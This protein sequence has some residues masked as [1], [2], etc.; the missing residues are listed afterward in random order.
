M[1]T[2]VSKRCGTAKWVGGDRVTYGRRQ[3]TSGTRGPVGTFCPSGLR[4]PGSSFEPS[5]G[6]P[7]TR[8]C[9]RFLVDVKKKS[10]FFG[11]EQLRDGFHSAFRHFFHSLICR[12]GVRSCGILRKQRG[13]NRIPRMAVGFAGAVGDG[14]GR[15]SYATALGGHWGRRGGWRPML[16]RGGG[17]IVSGSGE[18]CNNWGHILMR[19]TKPPKKAAAPEHRLR[20]A[21]KRGGKIFTQVLCIFTSR[22]PDRWR[23]FVDSKQPLRRIGEKS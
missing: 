17:C 23:I 8:N 14:R 3:R 6:G 1:C 11:G 2:F 10:C 20:W 7:Q 13:L 9:L 15:R 22:S 21:C 19:P 5:V 12:G 18:G 4:W 16:L